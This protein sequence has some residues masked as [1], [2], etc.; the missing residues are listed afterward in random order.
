MPSSHRRKTAGPVVSNTVA[1][2]KSG[3]SSNSAAAASSK[4]SGFKNLE[5]V[6][7]LTLLANNVTS[8]DTVNISTRASFE[9]WK[10]VPNRSQRR[11]PFNFMADA[12]I[13]HEQ[14][15]QQRYSNNGIAAVPHMPSESSSW[16]LAHTHMPEHDAKHLALQENE[17]LMREPIGNRN[18]GRRH[19]RR[20]QQHNV[21]LT[22][23][24]NVVSNTRPFRSC[25]TSEKA[26]ASALVSPPP[27][28]RRKNIAAM[29]RSREHVEVAQRGRQQYGFAFFGGA[30]GCTTGSVLSLA[31]SVVG[32]PASPGI[33]ELRVPLTDQ[34]NV[35]NLS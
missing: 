5:F 32:T 16:M 35:A 11:L 21:A 13:Q 23:S 9:G 31:N 10:L 15:H 7:Q 22:I 29:R 24:I 14:Q 18:R 19:H 4:P 17:R 26:G 3:S 12:G 20:A 34:H 6:L 8:R 2:P 28:G 25:V 1:A 27:Y 30:C 33:D